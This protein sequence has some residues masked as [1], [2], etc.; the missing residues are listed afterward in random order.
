MPNADAIPKDSVDI[1]VSEWM[2]YMMLT[3]DVLGD[4]L[5]ARDRILKEDGLSL[6]LHDDDIHLRRIDQSFSCGLKYIIFPRVAV[7][8]NRYVATSFV[9][10]YDDSFEWIIIRPARE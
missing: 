10:R 3:E 9:A 1:L 8:V 7:I 5:E 4:L 2:G 6:L